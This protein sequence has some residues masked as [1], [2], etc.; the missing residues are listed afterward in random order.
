[1]NEDY[2]SQ[3]KPEDVW[4]FPKVSPSKQRRYYDKESLVHPAKMPT[5][6]VQKILREYSKPGEV[7]LD[8]MAGIGTTLVEAVLLGRNAIGVEYEEK[9]KLIVERNLAA[10]EAF[11]GRVKGMGKGIVLQGDS[12][13]LEKVLGENA[14]KIDSIAFS[15]PYGHQS[16]TNKENAKNPTKLHRDKYSTTNYGESEENIGNLTYSSGEVD[17]IVTSPPFAASLAGS[18]NDDVQKFKHGSAGKDYSENKE[19]K[20]QLANLEYGKVDSI[21]T[22][23]PFEDKTT[24]VSTKMAENHPTRKRNN[25]GVYENIFYSDDKGDLSNLPNLKGETYLDAMLLVYKGCFEVLKRGGAMALV[26]KNFVRKGKMVRL[27]LDTIK[28]CEAAGFEFKERKYRKLESVSF[29]IRNARK[30]FYKK[31]PDKTTGDPFAEYEDV[32]VFVK[33]NEA[34]V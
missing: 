30:N 8:P 11:R 14:G 33:K 27:D 22:S 26:T 28:L 31:N 9:F 23:P 10:V 7:V 18:A 12:R 29:W 19:D 20:D 17:A 4:L 32:L 1:M 21:I 16:E 2:Y 3:I 34:G 15:P 13:E 6:F 25:F 5:F 24:A